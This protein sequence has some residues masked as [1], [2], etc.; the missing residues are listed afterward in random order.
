MAGAGADTGTTQGGGGGGDWRPPGW[1]RVEKTSALLAE[2]S[3]SVLAATESLADRNG[4]TAGVQ[5]QCLLPFQ[6]RSQLP[7]RL[8]PLPSW[9][10]PTVALSHS[11]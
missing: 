8:V 5:S 2:S 6:P 11:L 3:A 4:A 9:P 7:S 1:G 10:L